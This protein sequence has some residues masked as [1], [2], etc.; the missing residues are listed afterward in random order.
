MAALPPTS[1]Q[2]LGLPTKM[3]AAHAPDA[4]FV[5]FVFDA[6][7]CTETGRVTGPCVPVA[8]IVHVSDATPSSVFVAV[9]L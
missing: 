9:Q 8:V 4:G 7:T 3:P 1:V 6:V 5:T 2:P